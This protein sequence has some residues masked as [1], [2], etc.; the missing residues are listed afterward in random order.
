MFVLEALAV[1]NGPS[2]ALAVNFVE[3]VLREAEDSE[4]VVK[5][6]FTTPYHVELSHEALYICVAEILRKNLCRECG[7]ILDDSKGV[8]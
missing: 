7:Y 2:F 5:P 8:L 6:H 4:S 1:Y 3:V